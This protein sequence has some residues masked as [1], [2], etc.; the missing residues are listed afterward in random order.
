MRLPHTAYA[1]RTKGGGNHGFGQSFILTLNTARP[2]PCAGYTLSNLF[3][4]EVSIQ[5][6]GS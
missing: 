3:P 2:V 6:M 5:F 1:G 4:V